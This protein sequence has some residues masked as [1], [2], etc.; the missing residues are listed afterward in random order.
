MGSGLFR[1]EQCKTQQQQL[2]FS[3]QSPYHTVQVVYVY[4]EETI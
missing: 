2:N 1:L 4:K 3:Y